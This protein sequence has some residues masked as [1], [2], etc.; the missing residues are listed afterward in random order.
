MTV[1]ELMDL[2]ADC[3]PDKELDEEYTVTEEDDVV[4][5]GWE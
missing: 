5:I 3:D 4:I 2:L 1:Q